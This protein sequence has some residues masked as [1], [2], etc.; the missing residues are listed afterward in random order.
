MVPFWPEIRWNLYSSVFLAKGYCARSNGPQTLSWFWILSLVLICLWSYDQAL[1]CFHFFHTCFLFLPHW[2]DLIL[3]ARFERSGAGDFPPRSTGGLRQVPL[4]LHVSPISRSSWVFP[5][6]CQRV[7]KTGFKTWQIIYR[8][9]SR[10]VRGLLFYL[11]LDLLS[12]HQ[13][14]MQ[15]QKLLSITRAAN[16]LQWRKEGI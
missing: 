13:K 11:T 2:A 4:A 12:P 3:G 15:H 1:F 7:F 10:C 6:N 9:L 5:G 16:M 14:W 8:C